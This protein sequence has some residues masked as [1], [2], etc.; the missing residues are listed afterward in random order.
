MKKFLAAICAA[1]VMAACA[2]VLAST[3]IANSNTGKFHYA[4]CHFVDKMNPA[5]KVAFNTRDE[6][7]GAGYVPCKRCK[8]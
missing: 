5:H 7:I 8:P 4:D 1:V 6:A 2:T 3:Y